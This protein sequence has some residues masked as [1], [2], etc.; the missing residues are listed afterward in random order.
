[1]IILLLRSGLPLK[2][3]GGLIGVTLVATLVIVRQLVTFTDVDALMVQVSRQE[4]RFRA[5]VR[6]LRHHPHRRPGRPFT[7]V[8]PAL[9]RMLGLS[10]DEVI[11]TR[12]IDILHPDDL[13][14]ARDVL[15]RAAAEPGTGV[16]WQARAR[17]SDGGW[18]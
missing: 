10:T 3:A 11:G 13:A 4:Q 5:L 6:R 7:Y 18:R 12:V 9:H 14:L 17:H 8:G 16:S 2:L 1:M 15:V